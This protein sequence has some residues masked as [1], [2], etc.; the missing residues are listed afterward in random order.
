MKTNFQFPL[1]FLAT[2]LAGLLAGFFYTW[3]FTI[4]QSLDLI[5][6]SN[7]ATAMISINANIRNG[8]FGVIF[9][10][11]PLS[12]LFS[13]ILILGARN[14]RLLLWVSLALAFA[15]STL[16]ITF[17]KHLP[18]NDELANSSNWASYVGPWV[19]WNHARMVTSFLAFASMLCALVSLLK[20]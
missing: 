15:I 16:V 3:S 14:K 1:L 11:T 6:D 2:L 4:M 10:G 5:D 20:K 9:F 19:L 8:W 12:I 18:L 7:A 13:L 17:S